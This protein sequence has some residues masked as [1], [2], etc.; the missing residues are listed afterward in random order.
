MTY[1]NHTAAMALKIGQRINRIKDG[2]LQAPERIQL[3]ELTNSSNV[4]I[5]LIR[6]M[7]RQ[8]AEKTNLN[9]DVKTDQSNTC[10][11]NTRVDLNL[12]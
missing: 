7:E 1:Y 12:N 2:L 8:T 5:E 6:A 9:K 10:F 11:E 4:Q 3:H